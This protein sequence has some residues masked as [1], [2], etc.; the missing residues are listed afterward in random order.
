[1]GTVFSEFQQR[2][3][4][5][6]QTSG[7]GTAV[8]FDGSAIAEV[9][10][11]AVFLATGKPFVSP[12]AQIIDQRKATGLS[13]A[14]VGAS[15]GVGE[16]QQGMRVPVVTLEA[17]CTPNLLK[18]LLWSLLQTGV[19]EAVGSPF[20]LTGV[21]YT[22]PTVEVWATIVDLL[23]TSEAG[24]NMAIHGAI[25]RTL[26]LRSN[27]NDQSVKLVAEMVGG[28]HVTT[29]DM[30]SAT[31]DIPA[32]APIL[33]KNMDAL[34]GAN[35]CAGIS[36]WEISLT[37]NAVSPVYGQVGPYRHVLK[38]LD[39]SGN[40]IISRGDVHAD[41]DLNAQMDDFLALTDKTL[42][43]YW[44]N[45]PASADQNVSLVT[46]IIRNA[47]PTKVYEPDIGWQVPFKLASDGTNSLS[48][49]V[50]DDVDRAIP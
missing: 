20:V 50:A 49:T 27:M 35:A 33:Y 1:M 23:S 37:N 47:E 17:D 31:I 44:G 8:T 5:G 42:T 24:Q 30:S 48:W 2:Y 4:L 14:Y 11:D 12:G 38:H 13:T 6:F 43:L 21:P 7:I 18:L 34:L 26:T 10:G 32:I 40:F 22:T 25:C 29:L 46:N 15:A 16:I 39:G 45:T 28:S 41:D 9:T 3:L 36:S 19:S